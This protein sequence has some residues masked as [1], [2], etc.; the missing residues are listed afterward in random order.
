VT[1][2]A[3]RLLVLQTGS[4]SEFGSESVELSVGSSGKK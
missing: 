2:V 1:C 3:C 4:I